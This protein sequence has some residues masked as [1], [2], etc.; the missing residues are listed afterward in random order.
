MKKAAIS[1]FEIDEHLIE[2]SNML[3]EKLVPDFEDYGISLER[4]LL[5]Q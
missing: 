4:F 1:I 2:F 3:R 5:Q